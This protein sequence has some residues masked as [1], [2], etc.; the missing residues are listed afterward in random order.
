MIATVER[1]AAVKALR[2][3]KAAVTALLSDPVIYASESVR[4]VAA[5]LFAIEG[6][7]ESG[8]SA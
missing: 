2:E 1:A 7:I 8:E 5:A 6:L 4:G 3:A